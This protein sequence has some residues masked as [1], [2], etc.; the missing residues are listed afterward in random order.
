MSPSGIVPLDGLLHSAERCDCLCDGCRLGGLSV[1]RLALAIG[2]VF[3]TPHRQPGQPGWEETFVQGPTTSHI[4]EQA[5]RL[6]AALLSLGEALK[7]EA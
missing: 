2:D 6:R 4:W 7:E 5:E 3:Y 1:E